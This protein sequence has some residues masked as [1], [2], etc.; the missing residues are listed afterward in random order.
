VVRVLS[1]FFPGKFEKITA[2]IIVG[3]C[4]VL[5]DTLLITTGQS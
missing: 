2:G 1:C 4:I 3:I 5:A